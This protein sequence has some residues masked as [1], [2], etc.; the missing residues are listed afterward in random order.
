MFIGTSDGL[1]L[2]WNRQF[3][4]YLEDLSVP[5]EYVEVEGVGHNLRRYLEA[6]GPE[7]FEFFSAHLSVP[8]LPD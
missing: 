1:A 6:V 5:H 7:M 4:S 2:D 8:G 3:R